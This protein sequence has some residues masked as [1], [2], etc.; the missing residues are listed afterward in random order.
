MYGNFF[1]FF[2]RETE[3]WKFWPR[4]FVD[5]KKELYFVSHLQ[6]F[7]YVKGSSVVNST[8]SPNSKHLTRIAHWILQCTNVLNNT[9]YYPRVG[10]VQ[11]PPL[12]TNS[13]VTFACIL[14]LQ[15]YD[16]DV[17]SFVRLFNDGFDYFWPEVTGNLIA[18]FSIVIW[19]KNHF[20]VAFFY[21]HQSFRI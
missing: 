14:A 1:V 11:F 7:K 10:A 15:K 20:I 12:Q 8:A 18:A 13:T 16:Y 17:F 4:N 21:T 5:W 9:G 6:Y 3:V 19:R 2:L